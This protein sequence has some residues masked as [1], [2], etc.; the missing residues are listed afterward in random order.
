MSLVCRDE[1]DALVTQY[2]YDDPENPEAYVYGTYDSTTSEFTWDAREDVQIPPPTP[3]LPPVVP[4]PYQDPPVPPRIK[5]PKPCLPP[6][7]PGP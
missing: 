1:N 3:I 7:P 4:P 6:R 2:S 5:V